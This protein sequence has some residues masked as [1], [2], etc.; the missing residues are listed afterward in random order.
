MNQFE[1]RNNKGFC[2]LCESASG[3]KDI[4]ISCRMAGKRLAIILCDD[5]VTNMKEFIDKEKEQ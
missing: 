1:Y 2:R 3:K 5:C 4:V